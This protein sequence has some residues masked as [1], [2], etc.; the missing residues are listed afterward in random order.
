MLGFLLFTAGNDLVGHWQPS[1]KVRM[2][3]R[4]G[5]D[6]SH[7]GE[8]LA[9]GVFAK[10][11]G[12]AGVVL[13]LRRRLILGYALLGTGVLLDAVRRE[14]FYV[15]EGGRLFDRDNLGPWIFLMLG[16]LMFWVAW[17]QHLRREEALAVLEEVE[18]PA[19]GP[20]T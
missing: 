13:A 10:A 19:A 7:Q 4:I 8:K 2:N 15:W 9:T 1:L 17:Q 20:P 12:A 18:R 6:G 3:D 16:L 11:I 14:V 5:K